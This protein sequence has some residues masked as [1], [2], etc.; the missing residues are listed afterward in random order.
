MAGVVEDGGGGQLW[1]RRTRMTATADNDSQDGRDD[2]T[3][4]QAEDYEGEGGE[5]AA[6]NNHIRQ[7]LISLPSREC[8]K[9]KEI[10]Y[11]QKDFFQQYGL[12]GWIF[13]PAKMHGWK[14]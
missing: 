6:K 7:S 11:M 5:R 12:S 13:A 2:G 8:K 3:Q 9:N 14:F 1:Q 10:E 4:D